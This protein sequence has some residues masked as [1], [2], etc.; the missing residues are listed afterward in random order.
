MIITPWQKRPPEIAHLLNPAFC[1]IV[2][3]ESV[4]GYQ[5]ESGNNMPFVL[6]F[7]VLPLILHRPTR[8]VLPRSVATKFHSWIHSNQS[9]LVGF[10]DRTRSLVNFTKEAI[11]W[12]MHSGILIVDDNGGLFTPK[13]KTKTFN[14]PESSDAE[15]C[16]KNA[17]FL[18]RWLTRSGEPSTIYAILGIKP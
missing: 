9:I 17:Y 13:V 5:R 1:S 18:G 2:L 7:L 3:K 6:A 15:S 12:S 10:H 11:Y 16:I 4:Y 8:D 14:F